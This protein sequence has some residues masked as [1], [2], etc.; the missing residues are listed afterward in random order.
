MH[1]PS[2]RL[3]SRWYCWGS[4]GLARLTARAIES[5]FQYDAKAIAPEK[6]RATIAPDGP[7][8][9]SKPKAAPTSER[10]TTNEAISS[11]LRRL[12]ALI[13]SNI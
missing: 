8:P 6:T 10:R 4:A 2:T 9:R 7:A 1:R 11:A 3:C 12:L 13:S 5:A